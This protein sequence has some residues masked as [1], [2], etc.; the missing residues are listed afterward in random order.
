MLT[1]DQPLPDADD[2][3]TDDGEPD[4]KRRS[5]DPMLKSID[6]VFAAFD[7]LPEGVRPIALTLVTQRYGG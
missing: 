1:A 4:R 2:A 7:E 3:D 5:I 6:R